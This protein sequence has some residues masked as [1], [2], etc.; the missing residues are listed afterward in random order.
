M[1]KQKMLIYI[2]PASSSFIISDQKLLEKHYN[3]IPFLVKQSGKKWKFFIDLFS[4]AF[5]TFP[6]GW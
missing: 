1:E 5:F 2:K 6:Y 4:L 3:V